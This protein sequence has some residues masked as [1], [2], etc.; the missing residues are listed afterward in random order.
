VTQDKM[1]PKA[2]KPKPGAPAASKCQQLRTCRGTRR[3]LTF[4]CR[5]CSRGGASFHFYR[6]YRVGD[7]DFASNFHFARKFGRRIDTN[8][9]SL[10]SL[11]HRDHARRDLEH[12]SRDLIR[13]STNGKCRAVQRQTE[14]SQH[15]YNFRIHRMPIRPGGPRGKTFDCS[16]RAVRGAEPATDRLL[17]PC[18]S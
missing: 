13:F 6:V 7:R 4:R 18:R 1:S 9:Q 16:H 3:T 12:G 14:R 5:F 10:R 8:F 11:L 17:Q 15:T 2:G